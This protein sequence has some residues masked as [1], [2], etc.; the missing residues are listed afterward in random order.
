MVR[1]YKRYTISKPPTG[2]FEMCS[3]TQNKHTQRQKHHNYFQQTLG[4]KRIT[5]LLPPGAIITDLQYFYL[6]AIFSKKI[7]FVE[8]SIFYSIRF[9][10]WVNLNRRNHQFFVYFPFYTLILSISRSRIHFK[11]MLNVCQNLSARKWTKIIIIWQLLL[12]TCI[13][14]NNIQHS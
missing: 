13:F 9:L 4:L 2:N 11:I 6:N 7:F 3:Y 8:S 12:N 1:I 5:C 10:C 14:H